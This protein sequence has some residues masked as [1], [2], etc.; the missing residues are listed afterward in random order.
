MVWACGNNGSVPYGQ[1]GVD[2][3]EVEDGYEIDPG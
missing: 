1:K 2:G 3:E